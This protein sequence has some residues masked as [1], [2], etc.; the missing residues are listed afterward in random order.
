MLYVLISKGKVSKYPYSVHDFRVDNPNVSMPIDPSDDQ[1]KEVGIY[2]V[3]Q[4][5]MPDAG[6]EYNVSEGKPTL[7]DGIWTQKW[8]R[9]KVSD[10]VLALRQDQL[11][12]AIKS[13]AISL[14]AETDWAAISSVSNPDET[15][16]YLDNRQEYLD[17][18]NALR[19]IVFDTPV[20]V[21]QWPTKPNS[22]WKTV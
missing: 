13:K 22:I 7:I 16:P 5:N 15:N 1:L 19:K 8:T 6:I 20:T 4:V 10:D 18:R 17:Y 2:P 12:T 3:A 21:D 14:L 11:K 9:T